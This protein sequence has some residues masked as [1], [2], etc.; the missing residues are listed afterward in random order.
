MIDQNMPLANDKVQYETLLEAD[1]Y[2]VSKAT[3]RAGG[4]TQWHYH[5]S[6]SDRWVVVAGV[7]TVEFRVGDEKRSVQVI[8]YFSVDRGVIHHV[9]NETENDVTYILIQSGG[10]RD[11]VLD[12]LEEMPRQYRIGSV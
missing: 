9:K 3:V 8:D 4:E 6:V 1:G 11:I 12:Q 2:H 7:L 5:T 10:K